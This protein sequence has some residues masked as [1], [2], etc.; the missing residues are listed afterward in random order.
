MSCRCCQVNISSKYDVANFL[1][2]NYRL[3]LVGVVKSTSRYK[4]D[5]L[6]NFCNTFIMIYGNDN[7]RLSV[8]PS[9]HNEK[10][11]LPNLTCICKTKLCSAIS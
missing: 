4:Y 2:I 1:P 9:Q 5:M 6:L 10:T 3:R 8:L 11:M 7:D